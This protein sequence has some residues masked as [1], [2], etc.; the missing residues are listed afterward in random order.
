MRLQEEIRLQEEDVRLYERRGEAA[1]GGDEAA[2]GDKAAGGGG[3]AV[4]ER[5][6]STR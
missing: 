1:G 5:K 3:E 4:L 6:G 2:G